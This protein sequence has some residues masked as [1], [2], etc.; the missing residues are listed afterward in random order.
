MVTMRA[1]MHG[2]GRLAGLGLALLL[3]TAV[4]AARAAIVC[5]ARVNRTAVP[6]GGELVLTVTAEGDVGWSV[7]FKLPDLPGVRIYTGGTNQSMS[8]VNGQTRSSVSRTW[9][10]RVEQEGI[11]NIGPVLVQAKGESCSTAPLRVNVTAPQADAPPP[12]DTG[13]RTAAPPQ[14][15]A[16]DEPGTVGGDIFV[17]LDVDKPEPWLGEQIILTFRYWRRVQ[18][19]NNPSY[20]PPRTEGFWRED[21]GPERTLREVRGGRVYSVTE[22]RY[23]LFP[24]RAGQLVIE[25]AELIFPEDVFDRF[26]NS[27]RRSQGPRVLR[28]E[29][30]VVE[31]RALP[32][33]AAAGFGG[34]VANRLQLTAQVSPD[35]VAAGEPI[36][37]KLALEADGFLK[38]FAGLE[39]RPTEG[40]RMHD[41]AESF[42]TGLQGDRL[43]GRLGVEKVLVPEREGELV[44]PAT[45]LTWFDAD[46]GRYVSS[47]TPQHR[48][49]V[50]RGRLPAGEEESSG[51]LRSEISRLGAD[52]AFIHV[53]PRHLRGAGD[54]FVGSLVWWILLL[55]PFLLLGAW[56]LALSRLA[57]E[58]R[59][60]AGRRRRRAMATARRALDQAGGDPSRVARA[61][62]AYVADCTDR[63]VAAV[64]ATEV[65]AYGAARGREETGRSL[66]ALLHACD[67]AR[68]GGAAADAHALAVEAHR[69]LADLEGPRPQRGAGG[70]AAVLL[71]A[72]TLAATALPALAQRGGPDPARLLAEGNQA[73]T[74]GDLDLAL[75]RYDAARAAGADDPVLHYNLGNTHAR[76]GELGLAVASYLRAQRLDPRDADIRANL[77]WVRGHNRDLELT[78][79]EM[80]LFI[81]QFTML[82]GRF[83]LGEWTAALLVLLWS[84]GAVVAWGW[85]R[86]E[87]GENLRRVGL[88]VAALLA[89][90]TVVTAWRW[91]N[92]R[93]VETAVVVAAEAAVRSGPAESFP[94]LFM[95]HDG[96]SVRLDGTRPDWVRVSLGGDWQGWLPREAV[97]KV[98]GEPGGEAAQGR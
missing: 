34:L 23:A 92:E 43:Q 4:P 57:A 26:F 31:V 11:L 48:V 68:F 39:V 9:Y 19:W 89:L 78:S 59:D 77:A 74:E 3:L 60:P 56:R 12:A 83:T 91:Q 66:T 15:A 98:R 21:L 80:P 35:T 84:L 2:H 94:V 16:P 37:L 58:R 47:T 27:R 32:V 1:H 65:E 62:C 17:T 95:V 51:F 90:T 18:P 86:E 10:L 96:L 40:A 75:D 8:M 14:A 67:G 55:L 38:G 22:I 13:N 88:A 50:T 44:I 7:D 81:R 97:V 71:L 28:T 30:L 61:V 6:A 52:L 70:P 49:Q 93:V 24:T 76:R 41:A 5:E 79:D 25:P 20:T 29:R 63:P 53:V 82:V 73:Y 64:T 87:F 72:C 85:Y 46:A 45:N 54:G 42:V 36:E 33:P 69:L